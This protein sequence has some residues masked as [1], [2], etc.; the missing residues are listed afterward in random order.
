MGSYTKLPDDHPTTISTGRDSKTTGEL[1]DIW[2]SVAHGS[3][4]YSYNYMRKN[5]YEECLFKCEDER[6]GLDMDINRYTAAIETFEKIKE[7][8]EMASAKQQQYNN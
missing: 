8:I 6:F 2:I 5:L 3:E 1:N 7:E 4:D